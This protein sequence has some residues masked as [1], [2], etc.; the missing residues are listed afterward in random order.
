MQTD[1][2]I[3]NQSLALTFFV[4]GLI[5]LFLLFAVLTTPTPPLSGGEGVI[6][7]IGYMDAASGDEQPTSENTTTDPVV[8]KVKPVAQTEQTKIATQD[9]EETAT[10]PVK[11]KKKPEIIKVKE[12]KPVVK[13]PEK[14]KVEE[15]KPVVDQR[16]IYKGKAN[17][18]KSQGTATSGTGDQGN[19]DGDPNSNLYGKPG[20][21][22][23][24]GDGNGTGS[25]VGDGSAPGVSFSLGGRSMVRLPKVNDNSQDQG[26][27]VIDIVVDKYGTV[28]T[29]TGPGRGSTTTST[30]L[31][32]KA[33]EA[34]V[35]TKF[36]PSPQGVEEQHGTITFVF[37]VR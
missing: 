11:E 32:R 29:A 1:T 16:A 15:Y 2:T 36:S 17:N 10:I 4:H 34:A 7:N 24:S 30:N 28:V 14:V 37:I 22:N 5:F 25:G 35:K 31:V 9:L 19:P 23:G 6:V 8:E 27:V 12:T 26:K 33:K 21:G 20:S 13:L 18:S 3:R